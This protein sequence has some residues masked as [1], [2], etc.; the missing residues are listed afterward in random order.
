M[1]GAVSFKVPSGNRLTLIFF[2]SLTKKMLTEIR[3]ELRE[4]TRVLRH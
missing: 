3:A 2:K 1:V 4:I